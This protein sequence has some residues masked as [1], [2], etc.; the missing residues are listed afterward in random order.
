MG[1][2]S[3][4]ADHWDQAYG[5]GDQ[6][7]SWFQ[8]QAVVSLRVLDGCDVDPADSVIDVGG[9][10]STLVDALLHRGHSD[11]TVL[12]ISA[13]A[14]HAAQHRLGANAERVSWLV[15]NLLSWQPERTWQVWHDRAVFHFLTVDAERKRYLDALDAATNTGAVCVFATFAPAGPQQCSGLP[16]ARYDADALASILGSH[17]LPIIHTTEEHTTPSGAIQPFTWAA[18]RRV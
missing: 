2:V 7:R 18:F 5:H 17:W 8:S 12:D 9:G 10:A 6:T 16:V 15:A 3:G 13:I 4:A 1:G 11:I 14:L